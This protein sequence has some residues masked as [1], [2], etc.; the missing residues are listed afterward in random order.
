MQN[1]SGRDSEMCRSSPDHLADCVKAEYVRCIK[2]L[3][4][5]DHQW[6]GRKIIV[7]QLQLIPSSRLHSRSLHF[8]GFA[9]SISRN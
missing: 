2:W 3:T 7:I 9:G 6:S 5:H 4:N 8:A 1:I